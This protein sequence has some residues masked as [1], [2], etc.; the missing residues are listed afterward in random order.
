MACFRASAY[1]HYRS[2]AL[3]VGETEFNRVVGNTLIVRGD[4]GNPKLKPT[5]YVWPS[6]NKGTWLPGDWG[7]IHNHEPHPDPGEEGENIFY[8]GGCFDRGY[9]SLKDSADKFW[10][11][12]GGKKSLQQWLTTVEGWD[13]D[14]NNSSAELQT[15]RRSLRQ[16]LP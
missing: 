12:P 16:P 8:L 11:H 2:A 7:G 5:L 9:E 1:V 14:P 15:F 4:D 10:G 3:T 6:K 13:G